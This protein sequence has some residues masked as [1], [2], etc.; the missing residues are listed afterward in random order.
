MDLATAATGDRR[1]HFVLVLVRCILANHTSMCHVCSC[2]R[3]A[4]HCAPVLFR[5]TL[6]EY[7]VHTST[8]Y[9]VR[10]HT[11]STMYHCVHICT[12]TYM[13]KYIVLCTHVRVPTY[14][15][16]PTYL[17]VKEWRARSR[18]RIALTPIHLW[19]CGSQRLT[20]VVQYTTCTL[21]IWVVCCTARLSFFF[22]LLHAA[23]P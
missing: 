15:Y 19:E 21:H 22:N 8:W 4:I 23:A 10:V 13:Y 14:T 11:G 17:L 3:R 20:P 18:D 2:T 1:P 9:Y 7:D 5:G 16:L 12:G 6:Y